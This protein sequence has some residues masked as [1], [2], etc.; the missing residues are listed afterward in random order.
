MDE[1]QVI[2]I[3][4]SK[5][6]L[7]IA[8]LPSG[9]VFCVP[10][11]ADGHA[12]LVVR[13]R[14]LGHIERIALEATGGYERSVAFTLFEA[15]LPAVIV[16]PRQ[17]RDYA[18]ATGRLAKTDRIDALVLAEF[19]LYVKPEVRDLATAEQQELANLTA[20]RRQLVV[21][22]GSEQQ[23]L[24]AAS[25]D[26]VKRSI[27]RTL[28]AL[29]GELQ[30][31][32][33]ALLKAIETDPAWSARAALLESVPG[34]G[35]TTSVMLLADLPELGTLTSRQIAALVGVAPMNND[36]GARR[37]KRRV[38][39][40]RG[41]VRKGLYMAAL[42]AARHNPTLKHLYQRLIEAGK[43]FKVAIT[44]CMRKLLVILNAIIKHNAP[45][46]P[47]PIPT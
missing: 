15:G 39:G 29:R 9:E 27:T 8:V 23:R 32:E 4:V 18:K 43:P 19:A 21:M 14:T 36:S 44:A 45:W 20:R 24:Q 46:N 28:K 47:E 17:S 40:G 41:R 5:K 1:T 33:I 13:L 25:S 26:L 16:N 22:I 42:T 37:G 34:I 35:K 2:G 6:R 10:N 38:R 30:D 11:D 7:D 3:D 12:K 31:I